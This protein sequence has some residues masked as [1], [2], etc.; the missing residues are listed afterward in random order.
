MAT[1]QYVVL[2]VFLFGIGFEIAELN[3]LLRRILEELRKQK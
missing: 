2:L 3:I 1:W